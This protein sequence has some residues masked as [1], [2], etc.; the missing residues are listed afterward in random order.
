MHSYNVLI[1]AVL[2]CAF[3]R[4]VSRTGKQLTPLP[5]STIK[6]RDITLF[7]EYESCYYLYN[8]Q[9]CN[10]IPITVLAHG[11]GANLVK[12]ALPTS[13]DRRFSDHRPGFGSTAR[14]GGFS[15]RIFRDF[16]VFSGIFRDSSVYF[17]IFRYSSGFFGKGSAR[18]GNPGPRAPPGI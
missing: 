2:K 9:C 16:L 18:G 12:V 11:A 5:S 3:F 17:G 4:T 6:D 7:R 13:G 14:Q 15:P 10:L 1:C 8:L